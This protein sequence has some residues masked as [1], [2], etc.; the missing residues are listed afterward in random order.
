MSETPKWVKSTYSAQGNCV[1]VAFAQHVLI[2]DSLAIASPVLEVS[3][4]VWRGL[5]GRV[6]AGAYSVERLASDLS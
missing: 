2:R 4:V 1:E 6:K 5:V 3:P